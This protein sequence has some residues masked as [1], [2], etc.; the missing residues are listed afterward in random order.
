MKRLFAVL[1][2]V[3]VAATL[4]AC[5][6]R[7][8]Y[9]DA[10]DPVATITLE[11]GGVMRFRLYLNEA[12]N[13]VA[14]FAS[15]ANR[16]FYDGQVFFRIVPGVLIQAGSP[17]NDG[18]G[19][20]GYAIKGEFS[21][22]G[23]DNTLSHLRGTLSMARLNGAQNYDTASSQFF[24][25]QGNY[26]QLDGSYA[27]FGTA[28]DVETLDTLDRIANRPVDANNAP[29]TPVKIASIRVDTHNLELKPVEKIQ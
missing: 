17:T 24:I 22:N 10:E 2:C 27:A 16:R 7:D 6:G 9:L 12:P 1:L 21:A 8:P 18:S 11:D 20:A 3:L 25:V 5:V 15:L 28:M 13:T 14:N 23:V 29:L 26:S 4:A 19:G